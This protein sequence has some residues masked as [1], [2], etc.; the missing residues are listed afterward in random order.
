MWDRKSDFA[1]VF[2]VPVS[3]PFLELVGWQIILFFLTDTI[4]YHA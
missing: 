4:S 1:G 3:Y 2:L